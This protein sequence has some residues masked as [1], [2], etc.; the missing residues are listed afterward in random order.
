MSR[1]FVTHLL[2]GVTVSCRFADDFNYIRESI[3][4]CSVVRFVLLPCTRFVHLLRKSSGR[5]EYCT[6]GFAWPCASPR[7][8]AYAC[9]CFSLRTEQVLHRGMLS[10]VTIACGKQLL[11]D[12][13]FHRHFRACNSLDGKFCALPALSTIGKSK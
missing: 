12:Q 2:H 1:C 11:A 8:R 6:I 7:Y 3:V 10:C 13:F 9:A 5:G 4:C